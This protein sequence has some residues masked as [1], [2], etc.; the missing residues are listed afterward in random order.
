MKKVFFLLSSLFAFSFFLLPSL[1][2]QTYTISG[3]IYYKSQFP[4]SKHLDSCKVFL[5]YNGNAID[6]TNSDNMGLYQF[7]TVTPGLYQIR[8]SCTKMAGGYGGGTDG[9]LI[10]RY[11]VGLQVFTGLNLAA[12][13]VSHNGCVNALDALLGEERFV[14]IINSFPSGD[15]IFESPSVEVVNGPVTL[16]IQ[17][18]CFGDVNG[19]FTPIHSTN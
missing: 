10:L 9:L 1:Q 18:L 3:G 16:D 17:G 2:A 15:W 13:D 14:G 5:F 7:N 19:S 12:A 4:S 8:V 6:S 11:F